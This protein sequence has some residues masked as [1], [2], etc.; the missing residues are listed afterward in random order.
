MVLFSEMHS[1]LFQKAKN[2]CSDVLSSLRQI[3]EAVWSTNRSIH[4]Q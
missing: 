4:K 2:F 1:Y 3:L